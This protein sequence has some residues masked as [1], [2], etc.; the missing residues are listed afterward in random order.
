MT[1]LRGRSRKGQRLHS[2]APCGRWATTT[3]IG[4]IRLDGTSECMTVNGA[5]NTE[6]FR[7]YVKEFLVP[8]LRPG[9]VVIMDNLSAHKNQQTLALIE[10]VGAK[11]VFLPPY[12]PDFNPIEMMWSKVKNCLRSMEARNVEDLD[13][14]IGY[15]L[16]QV[17]PKDALG[18]F[19]HAG[20]NFI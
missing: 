16:D 4:S 10:E 17:T 13:A 20:Y 8:V 15:A 7:L 18:W 6:V 5:T 11:A 19:T 3:M 14:A 12:S 9:D 1:R 2:S